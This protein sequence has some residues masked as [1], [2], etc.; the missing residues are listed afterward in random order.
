MHVVNMKE[1]CGRKTVV[2]GIL[3][4]LH[5]F[6]LPECE[7]IF[8]TVTSIYM[9]PELLNGLYSYSVFKGV[10]NI[11]RCPLS[12]KIPDR[13]LGSLQIGSKNKMA[14]LWKTEWTILIK[15]Q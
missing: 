15:F 6:S 3:N 7:H 5:I 9:R 4:E 10:S 14:I 12:T 8:F 11:G 13:N 1:Y 2:L